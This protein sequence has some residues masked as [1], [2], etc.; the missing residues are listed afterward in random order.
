[1]KRVHT[2]SRAAAGLLAL[3][4][5]M[6]SGHAA[7]QKK[8]PKAIE[9][10]G[11]AARI[12]ELLAVVP[13][14]GMPKELVEKAEAVGVFPKVDRETLMFSQI[15]HGFGVI[16][17]R[18]AG[19]W[20]PPAF[21]QFGGA[22]FGNPFASKETYAVIFLFMTK[23]AVAAFEKGGVEFKGQKKAIAGPV[24]SITDEQRKEVE[25]AHI[26]AYAYYNGRL[27][28]IEFK[29]GFMKNFGLNP[30]N[31]IN[32]PLYG[33]K[34]REVLAGKKVDDASLPAGITAYRE[35][36]TKYYAAPQQEGALGRREN[37]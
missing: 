26:L 34:G 10:S 14:S 31:N 33:M 6:L 5:L 15:T 28:G 17:A 16:C 32:K 36:L 1:M 27:K 12:V 8:F 19:G 37:F 3:L 4:M 7:A 13:D 9:R 23:D 20:T 35:A 22:G 11:D 18:S 24:G 29:K 21:Y 30:D 25:G 2:A